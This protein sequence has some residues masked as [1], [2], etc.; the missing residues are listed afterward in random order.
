MAR[1][2]IVDGHPSANRNHYIHALASAYYGGG[3]NAHETRRIDIA[4]LDFPVLCEPEQWDGKEVPPDIKYAQDQ[5]T[6]ADHIVLLYPLWLGDVPAR[7][8]A[9]LEQVARPGFAMEERENGTFKKLL[10]GKSARLIVTMGMPTPIY[11]LWFQAHS[12]KSLKRNILQF[13]G[14][15]PVRVTLIGHVERGAD[16]RREW[17]EKVE[18]LGA[19]GR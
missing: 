18:R 4:Q 16:Y 9:F 8:K 3:Q 5:I 10:K 7:L 6:W 15:N 17:L 13:M 11:R 14:F 1:I 19:T 12:V 2:L